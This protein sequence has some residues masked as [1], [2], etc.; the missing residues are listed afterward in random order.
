MGGGGT[1]TTATQSNSQIPDWAV[2][3][4]Q[5]LGTQG[6]QQLDNYSASSPT[7]QATQA[8]DVL[9][10]V[11]SPDYLNVQADPNLAA[12]SANIQR[13][14]KENIAQGVNR[15][16]GQAAA[17]GGLLSVKNNVAQGEV[18]RKGAADIAGQQS[19]LYQNEL[20]K[21][22]AAQISAMPSAWTQSDQPWQRALTALSIIRGSG[23]SST[24]TQNT[25]GGGLLNWF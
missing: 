7:P 23:G 16:A 19:Q 4:F 3:Y 20:D 5:K 13:Q 24:T 1:T 18:A 12:V 6:N 2:P 11:L 9:S 17:G 21:R 22:Q 25:S 15:V 10:K 14:G 8:N